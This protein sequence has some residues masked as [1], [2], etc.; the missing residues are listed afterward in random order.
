MLDK[1]IAFLFSMR[2]MAILILLFFVAIGYAT[3][4]ENDFGTQT[5]KALIYNTT[6]FELIIVLLSV[7]MIANINRY[8]LWR[9]EKWPVLLFHISFIMI[10]I[11][12]GI[13]RYV[14]FEGMMSIREG[15]QSNLIVSDRTFLQINV[16]NNA[17][18]YSYDK[19]LLLHNYEGPLE[20]LKSNNFSQ[21]VKFLDNDIS[22]DYIDYI[23][24]AVDT[25]IV[26][27]GIPT[28][29]IVLAGANGRET[30]YLQEGRAKRF[31]A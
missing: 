30:H 13:T 31:Q 18:Q 25:L 2:L 16:H 26:G 12:A 11:G 7:N 20:F 1:F 15:E 14:S 29:T 10:V 5:A 19:P 24:N 8:K 23:P 17:Y 3:F 4:I 6:W 22:I 9:K 28:L 27:E 21:D